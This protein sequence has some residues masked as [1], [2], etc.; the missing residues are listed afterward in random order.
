MKFMVQSGELFTAVA[1]RDYLAN[2]LTEM[3]SM[4]YYLHLNS[5]GDILQT[6]ES[7][8]HRSVLQQGLFHRQVT[9][10]STSTLLS[11]HIIIQRQ[12][13]VVAEKLYTI[14]S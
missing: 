4:S 14:S 6:M 1:T 3:H 12:E 2:A 7:D 11:I 10:I 13:G 8:L 5:W 9:N